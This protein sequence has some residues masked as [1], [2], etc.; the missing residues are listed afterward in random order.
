MANDSIYAAFERLWQHI[1]TSFVRVTQQ[2]L[3]DK[4]KRVARQN[5]GVDKYIVD[6]FATANEP[7]GNNVQTYTYSYT[8]YSYEEVAELLRLE[9]QVECRVRYSDSPM[10]AIYRDCHYYV[11]D[12]YI[13]FARVVDGDIDTISLYPY[14]EIYNL[15]YPPTLIDDTLSQRHSAADAF[16]VGEALKNIE[17]NISNN[18][19]QVQLITWEDDD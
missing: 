5:I 19:S 18:T 13:V 4:E 9:Q 15:H 14:D 11:E 6:I 10:V 8:T 3:T 16:V 17:N 12:A 2:S 7:D 1:A